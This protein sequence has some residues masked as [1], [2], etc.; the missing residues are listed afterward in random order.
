M[1]MVRPDSRCH[2]P[3]LLTAVHTIHM[4]TNRA[5][6]QRTASV[7][8]FAGAGLVVPLSLWHMPLLPGP[9]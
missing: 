5:D 8:W 6:V 4:Y 9:P 2:T 3:R 7:E 1:R